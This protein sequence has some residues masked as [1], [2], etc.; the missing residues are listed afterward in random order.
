MASTHIYTQRYRK[1]KNGSAAERNPLAIAERMKI[2][3]W[4]I[5]IHALYSQM[6]RYLLNLA[7]N[8]DLL[9]DLKPDLLP[10][11]IPCSGDL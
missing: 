3:E 2:E 11:D 6:K 9:I 8:A 1:Q 4:R 5:V 7:E 10:I